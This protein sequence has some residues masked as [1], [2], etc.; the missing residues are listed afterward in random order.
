MSLPFYT[1]N[2]HSSHIFIMYARPFPSPP[3]VGMLK[4]IFK[5]RID[6]MFDKED[7]FTVDGVECQEVNC[8][9][10]EVI[11]NQNFEEKKIHIP[12]KS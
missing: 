9:H 11:S 2:E 3:S 12:S 6:E 7:A 4:I 8:I 1:R 5:C 10:V